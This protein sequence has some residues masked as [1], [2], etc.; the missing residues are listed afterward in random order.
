MRS[1]KKNL[2]NLSI[3]CYYDG[4]ERYTTHK[5]ILKLSEIEKW[6]ESYIFTHPRVEGFSIRIYVNET[7]EENHAENRSP[8][9]S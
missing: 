1:Q 4:G 3:R 7:M 6:I 9:T 8:D 5:Q 2:Y